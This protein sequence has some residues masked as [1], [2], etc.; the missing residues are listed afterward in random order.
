MRGGRASWS[1]M[2]QDPGCLNVVDI[3]GGGD[4]AR[5]FVKLVNFT[6]DD[7]RKAASLETSLERVF[8]HYK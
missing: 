4:E 8:K 5:R 6:P 7:P 3:D 1:A 2:E